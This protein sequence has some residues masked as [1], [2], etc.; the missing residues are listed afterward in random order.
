MGNNFPA[1]Y[2]NGFYNTAVRRCSG[3]APTIPSSCDDIG[4]GATIG[5]LQS[6]AL[7]FALLPITAA[8]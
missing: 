3:A 8:M 7:V 4:I 6:A 5:P 1:V 2:D